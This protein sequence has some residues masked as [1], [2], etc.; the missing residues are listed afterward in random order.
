MHILPHL[1]S[2]HFS[3]LEQFE[4]LL[5]L[6][7]HI[8]MYGYLFGGGQIPMARLQASSQL[9][10][11]A[12]RFRRTPEVKCISNSVASRRHKHQ[13]TGRDI[14]RTKRANIFSNY[15]VYVLDLNC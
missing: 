3:P 2:Q 14:V 11:V 15:S 5:Q 7:T 13:K 10:A 8:I 6:G 1:P 4:S 9:R 12:P